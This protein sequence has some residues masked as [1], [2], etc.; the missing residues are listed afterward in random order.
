MDF[1]IY[2]RSALDNKF[3]NL[4]STLWQILWLIPSIGN[5][6]WSWYELV[7]ICLGTIRRID[8]YSKT[9]KPC[10]NVFVFIFLLHWAWVRWT[11]T[12]IE[13]IKQMQIL[14]K[15]LKQ[16]LLKEMEWTSIWGVIPIVRHMCFDKV[17]L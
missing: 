4:S 16:T 6:K 9:L 5:H 1:S 2:I 13:T 3:Y 14:S 10:Q 8:R 15:F 11:K 7:E 17:F 12:R